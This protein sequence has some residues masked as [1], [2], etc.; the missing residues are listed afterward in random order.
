MKSAW[1]FVVGDE[2]QPVHW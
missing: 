2:R 1:I